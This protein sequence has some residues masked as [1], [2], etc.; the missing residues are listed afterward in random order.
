[1][2]PECKKDAWRMV[3][4]ILDF[5][6]WNSDLMNYSKGAAYNNLDDMH[7]LILVLA[8]LYLI[9]FPLHNLVEGTMFISLVEV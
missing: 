9:L 5:S 1:M 6:G 2:Y 7:I 8:L 3:W 4:V